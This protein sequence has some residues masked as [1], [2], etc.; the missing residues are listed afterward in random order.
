MKATSGLSFV[1]GTM[2]LIL[3][4]AQQQNKIQNVIPLE[5]QTSFRK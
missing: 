4:A 5:E 2:D 3:E 1:Y